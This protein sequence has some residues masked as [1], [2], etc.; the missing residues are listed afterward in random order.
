MPETCIE[1]FVDMAISRL[2]GLNEIT[3]IPLY[4]VAVGI[5]R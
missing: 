1:G 3:E 4:L 2:V 5:A